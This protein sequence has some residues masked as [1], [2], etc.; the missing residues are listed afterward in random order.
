MER[1]SIRSARAISAERFNDMLNILPPLNWTGIGA[2]AESFRMSEMIDINLV[3]IFVRIG[4]QHFELEAGHLVTH[5]MAVSHC[6]AIVG[7][8]AA[9]SVGAQS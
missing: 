5:C 2:S 9:A 3:A 1:T 4:E 8:G 6:A 7:H